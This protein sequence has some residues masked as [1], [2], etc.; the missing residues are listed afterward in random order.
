[1]KLKYVVSGLSAV[2]MS[3]GAVAG[4]LDD[5][6]S[7]G[8]LVCGV[9]TGLPGFSATDD[10]GKWT[11]IDVDYCRAL[12]TAI[13]N[14]PDK[15]E[16]KPLSAKVRFTALNSGELDVL[17][18]NT[19]WTMSR[20]VDHGNFVG[21]TY[22]DGQG[23]M[24]KKELGV[25]DAK[26]LDGAAICTQTGTTTELNAADFFTANGLEYT[27]VAFEDVAEVGK[28]YEAGR[29]DVLTNDRS[30]LAAQRTR[31]EN[32]DDHV[33][34]PNIISKE[35][36]GPLVRAGDSQWEDIARWSL[37]CMLNAEENG[38]SSSNLAEMKA[39]ENPSIQRLLGVSG[40]YGASVGLDNGW[41]ANIIEKVGNYSEVYER[42]VGVETP[43][44]LER[45]LN[46]LWTDGG[47]QYAPP[48][49]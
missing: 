9:S 24:V 26:E 6:K 31:M 41:C 12:S 37:N 14:D 28:A 33:V 18:R 38:I 40:E 34:L 21:V 15:V 17:S 11:G 1:M 36:L 7:K 43:L 5:V 45:G 4:T 32:A 35:P 19:T 3:T 2:I 13:F 42:N 44:G 39:N 25:S 48:V 16:F 10:E 30:G 20:D 8:S 29:C 46:S 47:L 49:R 22:Y 27:I 23:F